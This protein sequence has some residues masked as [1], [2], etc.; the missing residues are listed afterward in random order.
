MKDG[1]V[2]RITELLSDDGHTLWGSTVASM[3]KD[4]MLVGTIQQNLTV[5]QYFTIY[6]RYFLIKF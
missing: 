2:T 6:R 5:Y 4:G 1:T 3:Y